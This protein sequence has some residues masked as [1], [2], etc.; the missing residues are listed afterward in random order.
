MT[1]C[2]FGGRPPKVVVM[3][4]DPYDYCAPLRRPRE[5]K[6]IQAHCPWPLSLTC[7]AAPLLDL[8]RY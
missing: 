3:V 6:P 2:T 7:A 8:R 1:A 4:R 5:P